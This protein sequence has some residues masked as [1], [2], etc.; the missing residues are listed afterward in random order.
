V[1]EALDGSTAAASWRAGYHPMGRVVVQLPQGGLHRQ[2]DKHAY[3]N[4]KFALQ[5]KMPLASPE[6][7]RVTWRG[8]QTL[9]RPLVGPQASFKLL[10]DPPV[11]DAP[12]FTV[13]AVKLGEMQL[14][15]SRGPATAPAWLFSLEGYDSPLKMAAALPSHLPR[16]PMERAQ[17]IP[18]YP[19]NRLVQI[20]AD[21]R[22]VSVVALHGVCEDPPVRKHWKPTTA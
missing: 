17:G 9:T 2:A 21:G 19:I 11:G 6:E 7:G 12:S 22:S 3:R 13:T 8:N 10:A 15:T 18:G 5:G 4:H 16:S 20:A 1:T 14:A